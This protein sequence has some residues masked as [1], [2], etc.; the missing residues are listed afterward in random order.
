MRKYLPYGL[1]TVTII[2]CTLIWDFIE[3]PYDNNNLIN[4]DDCIEL[5]NK[6][7][8]KMIEISTHLVQFIKK[9]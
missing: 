9:T 3:F 4:K 7:D 2:I 8:F 6:F 5:C 1:L